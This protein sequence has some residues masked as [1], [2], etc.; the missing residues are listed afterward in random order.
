MRIHNYRIIWSKI[1]KKNRKSKKLQDELELLEKSEN[2]DKQIIEE[3][4]KKLN[5]EFFLILILM[6]LTIG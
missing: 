3:N 6:I 1:T 2:E 4:N 5:I